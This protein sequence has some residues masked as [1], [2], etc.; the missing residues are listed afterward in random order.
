MKSYKS[1][2]YRSSSHFIHLQNKLFGF[3]VKFVWYVSEA[4]GAIWVLAFDEDNQK[5]II[6]N[7]EAMN[8]LS[9]LRHSEFKKIAQNCEGTLWTMR[10]L[11][12]TKDKYKHLGTSLW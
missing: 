2:I 10:Q 4:T 6:A 11:I 9:S 1:L 5:K 7:P 12:K 3:L 8:L